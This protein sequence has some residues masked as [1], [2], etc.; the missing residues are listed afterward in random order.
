MLRRGY[1]LGSSILAFGRRV[2]HYQ[3]P[4]MGEN[5]RA[6][7]LTSREVECFVVRGDDIRGVDRPAKAEGKYEA[8]GQHDVKPS[9]CI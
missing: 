4:P 7:T 9:D 8:K 1:V 6:S 2:E 5:S 3:Y